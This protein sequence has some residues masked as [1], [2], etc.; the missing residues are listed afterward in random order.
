MRKR[1]IQYRKDTAAVYA[2]FAAIPEALRLS[3][4]QVMNS[5]GLDTVDGRSQCVHTLQRDILDPYLK[6]VKSYVAKKKL[7]ECLEE[8]NQC[9]LRFV[10][11]F[12]LTGSEAYDRFADEVETLAKKLKDEI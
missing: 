5:M 3:K 2:A 6:D 8:W 11:A 9:T 7:K 1:N 10:T 12:G 4:L